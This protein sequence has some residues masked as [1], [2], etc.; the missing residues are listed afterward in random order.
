MAI[1]EIPTATRELLS[2]EKGY[3]ETRKE[4]WKYTVIVLL[5][6]NLF[7]DAYLEEYLRNDPGGMYL[8][9]FL[10]LKSGAIV[11]LF[12]PA[13]FTTTD[14]IL[15]RTGHYPLSC[16]ER[17]SFIAI[18]GFRRPE[19]LGL[20]VTDTLFFVVTYGKDVPAIIAVAL[21]IAVLVAALQALLTAALL[22]LR[23]TSQPI[24]VLA[25]LCGVGFFMVGFASLIFRTELISTLIPMIAWARTG[26]LAAAAGDFLYAL[27]NVGFLALVWV[28]ATAIAYRNC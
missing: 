23:R 15:S 19:I 25:G 22:A 4:A 24:T 20:V 28:G 26:I 1:L 7:L 18:S 3:R 6:L 16:S 17:L 14:K 13:Y 2:T 9:V 8:S 21:S 27:A 10:F 11:L 5:F 12:L